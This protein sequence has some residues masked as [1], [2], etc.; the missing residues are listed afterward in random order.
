[1]N[2]ITY[3]IHNGS[4]KDPCPICENELDNMKEVLSHNGMHGIHTVCLLK[5]HFKG[6]PGVTKDICKEMFSCPKCHENGHLANKTITILVNDKSRIKTLLKDIKDMLPRDVYKKLKEV[7]QNLTD[8][9]RAFFIRS[10][11]YAHKPEESQKII[12]RMT[13]LSESL[14][15]KKLLKEPNSWILPFSF[16]FETSLTT[17]AKFTSHEI[18]ALTK[19]LIHSNPAAATHIEQEDPSD[20]LRVSLLLA[21]LTLCWM[22]FLLHLAGKD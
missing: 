5:N 20:C 9:E 7:T 19:S 8:E 14:A 6:T 10:A 2:A 13:S 21:G 11:F 15:F 1:M 3:S 16:S 4:I 12:D 22:L 18:E 17:P